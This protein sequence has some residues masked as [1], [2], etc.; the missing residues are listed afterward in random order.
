MIR[1]RGV[2]DRKCARL[3]EQGSTESVIFDRVTAKVIY[4]CGHEPVS[5]IWHSKNSLYLD[6]YTR[7]RDGADK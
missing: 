7:N 5:I 4:E 1:C 6:T 3:S 2:S